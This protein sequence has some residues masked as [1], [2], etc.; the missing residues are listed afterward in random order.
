[1]NIIAIT[2]NP[3]KY[4][5]RSIKPVTYLVEVSDA[6]N[7]KAAADEA[8]KVFDA[9]C[10]TQYYNREKPIMANQRVLKCS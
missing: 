3:T 9:E 2:Y 1:M 8:V 6:N 7:Y 10:N 4:A 5:S